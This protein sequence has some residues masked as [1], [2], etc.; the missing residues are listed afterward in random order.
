MSSKPLSLLR[1]TLWRRAGGA[2]DWTLNPRTAA[3]LMLCIAFLSLVGWLYL[4]QASQIAVLGYRMEQIVTEIEQLRRD[5]ALLRY[6]IAELE[7]LPRIEAR[8]R[9]LGL[10]PMS[11]TTYLSISGDVR[12]TG[13]GSA[14]VPPT[15]EAAPPAPAAADPLAGLSFPSV[16]ELWAELRAQF[17]AWVDQR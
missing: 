14:E 3:G 8:A 7:T 15:P 11:R 6:Q 13:R 2:Q 5:N 9:Q 12:E 1:P 10:G 17:T 4:T 16:A